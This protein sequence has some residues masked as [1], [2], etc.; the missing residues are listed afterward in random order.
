L[1]LGGGGGG[2]GAVTTTTIQTT[3]AAVAAT[4]ASGGGGGSGSADTTIAT[5]SSS[6]SGSVPS[7]SEISESV[8]QLSVYFQDLR[9]VDIVE[10]ASLT[11]DTLVGLI[12]ILQYTHIFCCNLIF[13]FAKSQLFNCNL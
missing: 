8:L 12:G 10:S 6:S 4:S 7:S 1:G 11:V 3:A 5:S 2:G 9:Y 13:I